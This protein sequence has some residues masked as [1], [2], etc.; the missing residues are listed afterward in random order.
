MLQVRCIVCNPFQQNCYICWGEDRRATVID[1]GVSSE[2]EQAEFR[3][4]V[5]SEHLTVVAHLA[6]HAHLDHLFG[7]AWLQ[8]TYGVP[9]TLHEADMPLVSRLPSQAAAFGFPWADWDFSYERYTKDIRKG[10]LTLIPT[11]GH[12]PGGVCY[13]WPT[14]HVL[15]SGDTLFRCGYGRTDLWGGDYGTLMASLRKLAELPVETRV[16]PGHGEPTTIGA[17]F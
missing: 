9:V 17:E 1:C 8:R 5:D 13:Y 12:S 6:T 11:P 4:I 14:E 7:A 10:D 3:Q 2:Q 15:F 16:Y